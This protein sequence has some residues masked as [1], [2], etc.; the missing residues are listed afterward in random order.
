MTTFHPGP[1]L[2]RALKKMVP[3]TLPKS[4][5]EFMAI[6]YGSG[7]PHK[8]ESRPTVVRSCRLRTDVDARGQKLAR[9]KHTVPAK[10][11]SKLYTRWVLSNGSLVG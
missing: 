6:A 3:I 9:R 11:M 5:A 8:G 4:K 10:I 2:T 7:R 1:R